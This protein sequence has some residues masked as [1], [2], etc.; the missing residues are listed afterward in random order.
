VRSTTE[1]EP[2]ALCDLIVVASYDVV[3]QRLEVGKLGVEVLVR[4]EKEEGFPVSLVDADHV[5]PAEPAD[6]WRELVHETTERI[7]IAT[8][9]DHDQR[10]HT[11]ETMVDTPEL[12]D[13]RLRFGQELGE[14]RADGKQQ[15]RVDGENDGGEQDEKDEQRTANRQGP[16]VAQRTESLHRARW[17][18]A[19]HHRKVPAR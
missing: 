15:A 10:R 19:R 8:L 17:R 13:A 16:G 14:T 4:F 6:P 11:C 9:R 12:D 2:R 1:V 3:P 7:G 18:L 5:L